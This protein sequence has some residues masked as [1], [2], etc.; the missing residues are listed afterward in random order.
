MIIDFEP[1]QDKVRRTQYFLIFK[2]LPISI[3]LKRHCLSDRIIITDLKC[4][5]FINSESHSIGSIIQFSTLVSS[6]VY[7]LL[8]V[9]LHQELR[10]LVTLLYTQY[11]VDVSNMV[12][13]L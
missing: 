7:N 4:A 11:N 13:E 12:L 6:I 2:I 1:L 5:I 9:T 3:M 8:V 10:L